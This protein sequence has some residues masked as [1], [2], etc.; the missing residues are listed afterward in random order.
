VQ[1]GETHAYAM[2][3]E[4]R[5]VLRAV[6]RPPARI[7][8]T[9]QSP[10]ISN[11]SDP[12]VWP[13]WRIAIGRAELLNVSAP[14]TLLG[15]SEHG[16]ANFTQMKG[17]MSGCP[18]PTSR[19]KNFV[20]TFRNLCRILCSC[21]NSLAVTLISEITSYQTKKSNKQASNQFIRSIGASMFLFWYALGTIIGR[22]LA[23]YI[24]RRTSLAHHG[25]FASSRSSGWSLRYITEP[26]CEML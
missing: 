20:S 26:S 4:L 1:G 5:A 14:E 9:S 13:L 21:T 23:D 8:W 19:R 10:A 12:A 3:V 6:L 22:T 11:P 25:H 16:L 15:F 7:G 2:S 24:G 18:M 17:Q